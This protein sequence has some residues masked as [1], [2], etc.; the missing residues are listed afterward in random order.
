MRSKAVAKGFT[1]AKDE[2]LSVKMPDEAI[3]AATLRCLVNS[4]R[5]QNMT[6]AEAVDELI[7]NGLMR[8]AVVETY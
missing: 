4:P 7:D 3:D 1:R 6:V 8:A 5:F 2:L